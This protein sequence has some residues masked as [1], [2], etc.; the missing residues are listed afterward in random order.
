MSVS[1]R[2]FAFALLLAVT[3]ICVTLLEAQIPPPL[4]MLH[5]D[6]DQTSEN[7]EPLPL[8]V[9]AN[10]P[11]G[12]AQQELPNVPASGLTR[13]QSV[14]VA[15]QS[16]AAAAALVAGP[17]AASPGTIEF[18]FTGGQAGDSAIANLSYLLDAGG[19]NL[20]H[21]GGAVVEVRLAEPPLGDIQ[22]D[23]I[24]TDTAQ[25]IDSILLHPN[26]AGTVYRGV[27]HSGTPLDL[28]HVRVIDFIL[29]ALAASDTRL[30]MDAIR[31]GPDLPGDYNN[32]GSVD[33]ADYVVW[34]DNQ[35]TT[36]TLSNDPLGGTIDGRQFDQWR[37][38]FGAM[39]GTPATATAT[40]HAAP[41]PASWLM[42]VVAVLVLVART[43][44]NCIG[45]EGNLR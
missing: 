1:P 38:N 11:A 28:E 27:L 36:N 42:L 19:K 7:G 20:N 10:G 16:S 30:V 13:G 33:A 17:G 35:G 25:E 14:L 32:D 29:L 37:A 24:L 8:M 41:E 40:S 12:E 3:P 4:F 21:P 5:D 22:I 18:N 45:H 26:G 2:V 31:V 39:A 44:P 23:A 6:F 34:R 15:S 9:S 43:R